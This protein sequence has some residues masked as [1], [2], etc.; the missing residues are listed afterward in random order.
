M[1]PKADASGGKAG[2]VWVLERVTKSGCRKSCGDL[3]KECRA[4]SRYAEAAV[5]S[6]QAEAFWALLKSFPKQIEGILSL[7]Q[8]RAAD[9]MC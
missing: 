2:A 3:Y 8:A 6:K 1:N 5:I 9:R 7:A 4:H